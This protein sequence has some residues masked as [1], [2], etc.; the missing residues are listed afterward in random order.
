MKTPFKQSIRYAITSLCIIL[1]VWSCKDETETSAV[2]DINNPN[3]VAKSLV[4]DNATYVS[5]NPPAPTLSETA[6]VL[7]T[8]QDGESLFSIQGSKIIVNAS[9]ESGSANGFYVQID[10]ANG[11]YNISSTVASGRL[12]ARTKN[13]FLFGG[14]K[15]EDDV[16]F[17][18]EIP[19]NI[20]PGEFCISYCVY[21]AQNQ[22]SNIIEQC[23]IVT[24]LGGTNS[25]FLTAN[26][27]EY[28]RSL[29]YEDGE[30]VGGDTVDIPEYY[31]YAWWSYCNDEYVEY[32]VTETDVTDYSYLTLTSNGGLAI[33]QKYTETILDYENSDCGP[34][35][36]ETT[37]TE[38][39]TGAWSYDDGSKTLVLLYNVTYEGYSETFAIPFE[40]TMV[41]N[42][43]RLT[44]QYDEG[45]YSETF[46]TVKN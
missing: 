3:E 16:A 40:T 4:I 36:E 7:Y 32:L 15:Q 11:Y 9:I 26:T 5:G 25:N 34:V 1:L 6:P 42:Q 43:L 10:G 8:S 18:I 19:E 22:V 37:V 30:L 46:F 28:Q 44:L 35:Y 38:T 41:G 29:E 23:V 21:D 31:T 24:E 33:D 45:Y 2:I 13:K 17:S 20:E 14:R 27:W 39:L 12:A